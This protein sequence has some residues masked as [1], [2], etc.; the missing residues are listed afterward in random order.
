MG[1]FAN[2]RQKASDLFSGKQPPKPASRLPGLPPGVNPI[3][4]GA[5][6]RVPSGSAVTGI[7]QPRAA[8]GSLAAGLKNRLSV[9]S[10]EDIQRVQSELDSVR[11]DLARLTAATQND[12]ASKVHREA[13]HAALIKM[14]RRINGPA[15]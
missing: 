1:L 6:K 10:A 11:N 12:E 7:D 15:Q 8:S 5:R 9:A 14:D 4:G 2:L 13:L 3:D